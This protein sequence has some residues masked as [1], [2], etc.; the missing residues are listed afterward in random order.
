VTTPIYRRIAQELRQQIKSGAHEPGGQL[1]T[2]LELAERYEASRNTV[3]DAIKWLA[4]NGLV[5]T[6][7]GQGTFVLNR[8]TPFVTTLSADPETA[9]GGGGGA[10]DFAEVRERGRQPSDS[11]PKVAGWAG[12]HRAQDARPADAQQAEDRRDI[13]TPWRDLHRWSASLF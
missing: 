9:L 10:A 4:A 6:R 7:P 11:P 3:R 13:L 2:E 12:G 1:P 8:I 5:E